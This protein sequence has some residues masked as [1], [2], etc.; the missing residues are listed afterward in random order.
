MTPVIS[1]PRLILILLFS[2]VILIAHVLAEAPEGLKNSSTSPEAR[3]LAARTT[4]HSRPVTGLDGTFAGVPATTPNWG[5]AVQANIPS[6]RFDTIHAQWVIPTASLPPGA[7]G[8]GVWGVAAWIGLDG[9]Q[10]PCGGLL[11]GGSHTYLEVDSS[12]N[13]KTGAWIW[14]QWPPAA[15]VQFTFEDVQPGHE[16]EMTI[17][18]STPAKGHVLVQ[19]LTTRKTL[20][21]EL[22]SAGPDN[23]LCGLF[24]DWIVEDPYDT[25]KNKYVPFPVFS[26]VTFSNCVVD[27]TTSQQTN[28]AGAGLIKLSQNGQV[29][30]P[31]TKI[32]DTTVKVQYGPGN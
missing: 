18:A 13:Q 11:Q 31:V 22:F 3:R 16:I 15:P 19:D 21:T 10:P 2:S 6:G 24:A 26:P 29:L 25:S 17:F 7:S 30:A 28:A 1:A 14:A 20:D 23:N 5:G 4:I 8:E 27:T 12:G 9:I 32:T